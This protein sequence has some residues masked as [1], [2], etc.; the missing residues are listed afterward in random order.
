MSGGRTAARQSRRTACFAGAILV[1]L[2]LVTGSC[3]F[4]TGATKS[5]SAEL[6]ERLIEDEL[7]K[8]LDL[9]LVASCPPE[10][11]RSSTFTCTATDQAAR[12]LLIQATADSEGISVATT[13]VVR[14]SELPLAERNLAESISETIAVSTT[15]DCGSATVVIATSGRFTCDLLNDDGEMLAEVAVAI[16]PRE[17]S[18]FTYEVGT[19]S[20]AAELAEDLIESDL[21][22]QFETDLTAEC[23]A[24]RETAPGFTFECIATD[25]FGTS[26][27]VIAEVTNDENIIVE[28]FDHL[29]PG[30]IDVL[31]RSASKTL[32]GKLGDLVAVEC[33][34][35]L[36]GLDRNEQFLCVATVTGEPMARNVQFTVTSRVPLRYTVSFI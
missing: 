11:A 5:S 1:V 29:V 15:V 20:I 7:A 35:Q 4:S 34:D 23:P 6:A 33:G 28:A 8:D 3:S 26:M 32:T 36:L 13:N 2:A 30:V 17:R 31:E 25:S 12:Q 10:A 22:K 19:L 24:Q 27:P 18:G 21:A 14:S 9:V 16:N